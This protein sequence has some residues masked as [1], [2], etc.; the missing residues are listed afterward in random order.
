[1][2]RRRES[3]K[4]SPWSPLSLCPLCGRGGPRTA[5]RI[6]SGVPREARPVEKSPFFP[7]RD[8]SRP[9]EKNPSRRE[10]EGGKKWKQ[11]ARR[12]GDE[13]RLNRRKEAIRRATSARPIPRLANAEKEAQSLRSAEACP[14]CRQKTAPRKSIDTRFPCSLIDSGILTRIPPRN[15]GYPA[16]RT[17]PL[18]QMKNRY[19]VASCEARQATGPTDSR[20]RDWPRDVAFPKPR[21]PRYLP[22]SISPGG[23]IRYF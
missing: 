21:F 3:K 11:C 23:P 4:S 22:P 15:L 5:G 17:A 19:N 12:T 18:P 7:G 10:R 6:R 13:R 9:D 1:M 8:Q 20:P 14:A 16:P 2:G